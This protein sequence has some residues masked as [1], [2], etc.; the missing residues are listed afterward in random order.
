MMPYFSQEMASQRK[1]SRNF[2]RDFGQYKLSLTCTGLESTKPERKLIISSNIVL[3][4]KK[5][6]SEL[7]MEKD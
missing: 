6:V 4:L 5:D 7:F 3:S 2:E 1:P